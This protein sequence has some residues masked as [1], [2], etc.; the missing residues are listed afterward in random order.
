MCRRDN[1]PAFLK[2][3]RWQREHFLIVSSVYYKEIT[4]LL[5][6]FIQ[7]LPFASDSVPELW[8]AFSNV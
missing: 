2:A 3:F 6:L 8:Q 4:K 1:Q 5:K 7:Y